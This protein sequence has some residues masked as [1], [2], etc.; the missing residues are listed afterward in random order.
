M[1]MDVYGLCLDTMLMCYISDEE[2][3]DGIPKYAS[4]EVKA[5]VDKYGQIVPGTEGT[6]KSDDGQVP[7]VSAQAVSMNL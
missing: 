6:L 2:A 4:P 7:M 3:H 1:F 5:F